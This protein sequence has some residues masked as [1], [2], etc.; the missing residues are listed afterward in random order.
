MGSQTWEAPRIFRPQLGHIDLDGMGIDGRAMAGLVIKAWTGRGVA[1]RVGGTRESRL[2]Q[3]G[4]VGVW[5]AA[6][7]DTR[8]YQVEHG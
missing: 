5:S 3:G 8:A 2:L 4:R 6:C 1:P 7:G